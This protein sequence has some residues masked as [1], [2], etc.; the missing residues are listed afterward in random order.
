MVRSSPTEPTLDEVIAVIVESLRA[1]AVHVSPG[2]PRRNWSCRSAAEGIARVERGGNFDEEARERVYELLPIVLEGAWE[3]VRRGVLRPGG[4]NFPTVGPGDGT[5]FSLTQQGRAWLEKVDDE[6]L[7]LLQP[8]ATARILAEH[9]N[10]Y[11]PGYLQRANEALKAR[12]A[13]A[14]LACCAMCGAAAE[15]ILLALAIAR[16]GDEAQVLKTYNSRSGRSSII[17]MLTGQVVDPVRRRFVTYSEVLNYWRDDAAHGV[18][19]SIGDAHAEEAVS[20][21]LRLAQFAADHWGD[22]TGKSKPAAG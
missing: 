4:E 18:A 21:L 10:L 14:Y 12:N 11:G 6:G 13:M 3:L 1:H 15:S 17:N 20:R 16:S 19:S 2:R 9:R 5:E 7:V 8:G 22:L